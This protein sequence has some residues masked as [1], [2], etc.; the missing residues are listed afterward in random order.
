MWK[1]LQI[2]FRSCHHLDSL[3][4]INDLL[5]KNTE[6]EKESNKE[7]VPLTY[8]VCEDEALYDVK[9]LYFVSHKTSRHIKKHLSLIPINKEKKRY[10]K[11]TKK[12]E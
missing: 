12:I 1:S 9:P 7:K 8:D 6:L 4:G 10:A 3:V 2:F 5:F 11:N